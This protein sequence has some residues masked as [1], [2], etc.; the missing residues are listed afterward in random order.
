MEKQLSQVEPSTDPVKITKRR[1]TVSQVTYL[2]AGLDI[3]T[4]GVVGFMLN[5]RRKDITIGHI[6]IYEV[7]RLIEDRQDATPTADPEEELRQL[8][9]E[10]LPSPGY[11]GAT[12][13]HFSKKDS[14]T[15]PPYREGVDHDIKLTAENTLTNSLLYNMSL[16]QL[17]L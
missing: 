13:A 17:Q 1:P 4:V 8:I 14:D 12:L 9:A 5:A 15:L 2:K 7:D 10:K 16:E 3:T 6:S 11:A